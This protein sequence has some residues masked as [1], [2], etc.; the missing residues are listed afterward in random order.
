MRYDEVIGQRGSP[1]TASGGD[2]FEMANLRQVQTGVPGTIYIST[3]QASHGPRVKHFGGRPGEGVPYFSVSIER[4][5]RVVEVNGL[6]DHEV[7]AVAGDVVAWVRLNQDRL[8][9]F[10]YDGTTWFD[11]EVAAFKRSL[12]KLP[13]KRR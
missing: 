3:A 12:A 8:T 1:P 5:P 4:E 2:L 11:D 7:N 6:A 9:R 10:W 13:R